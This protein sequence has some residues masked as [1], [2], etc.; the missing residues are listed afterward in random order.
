MRAKACLSAL[1]CF[2]VLLT[3]CQISAAE[4]SNCQVVEVDHERFCGERGVQY[5]ENIQQ[6]ECVV[7]TVNADSYWNASGLLLEKDA[8]YHVTVGADEYWCDDNT[9]CS[10]DGW[11]VNDEKFEACKPGTEVPE[12]SGIKKWLFLKA[13]NYR[14]SPDADWFELVGVNGLGEEISEFPVGSNYSYTSTKSGEFCAYAN[15]LKF[16][17]WNNSKSLKVTIQRTD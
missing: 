13:E 12:L 5:L 15:D 3:V 6:G 17:Y 16:F 2:F 1:S 7:L 11:R 14:R 4:Q 8:T 9:K 10:A